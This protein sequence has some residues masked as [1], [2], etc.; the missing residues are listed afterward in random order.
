MADYKGVISE[1]RMKRQGLQNEI[2]RLDDV[3]SALE[4]ISQTGQTTSASASTSKLFKGVTLIFA[5]QKVLELAAGEPLHIKDVIERLESGGFESRARRFYP[6]VYSTL[7]RLA[8]DNGAV[9]KT[10]DGRWGLRKWQQP[11]LPTT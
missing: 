3:I 8:E 2:A 10:K 11:Q 7:Y 6:S 9:V 5:V 4:Q 1:L